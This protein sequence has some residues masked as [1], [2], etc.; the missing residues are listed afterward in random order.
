[1]SLFFGGGDKKK[2]LQSISSLD[3]K[4]TNWEQTYRVKIETFNIFIQILCKIKL[5]TA[6][7]YYFRLQNTRP[8]FCFN[9][10]QNEFICYIFWYLFRNLLSAQSWTP[11]IK[12][13]HHTGVNLQF[14][15]TRLHTWSLCSVPSWSTI[16]YVYSLLFVHFLLI[17]QT[18][19]LTSSVQL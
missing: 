2:R 3:A 18:T 12:R 15:C 6:K 10:F 9:Y 7:L 1:M 19:P 5:K 13:Q 16:F 11:F 4:T 8:Q 17:W 14:H